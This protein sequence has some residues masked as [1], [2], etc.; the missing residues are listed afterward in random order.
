V[1]EGTGISSVTYPRGIFGTRRWSPDNPGRV[2]MDILCRS[3]SGELKTASDFMWTSAHEFG[4]LLGL[5]SRTDNG[6]FGTAIMGVRGQP[7]IGSLIESVLIAHRT[8]R[9][10]YH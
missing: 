7:V 6:N 5:T 10:Q 9:Q 2:S 3:G 8:G 1:I 4:H